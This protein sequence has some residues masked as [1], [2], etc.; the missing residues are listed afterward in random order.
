MINLCLQ[1]ANS[2]RVRKVTVQFENLLQTYVVTKYYCIFFIDRGAKFGK[3]K[4]KIV[5]RHE[6]IL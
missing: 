3:E 4:G 1:K 6:N 5:F 2:K